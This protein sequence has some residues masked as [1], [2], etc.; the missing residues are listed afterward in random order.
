MSNE[1]RGVALRAA[2]EMDAGRLEAAQAVLA[3]APVTDVGVEVRK[4]YLALWR[5][6]LKSTDRLSRPVAEALDTLDRVMDAPARLWDAYR[7]ITELG[8]V[9]GPLSA[10]IVGVTLWPETLAADADFFPHFF[11][12]VSRGAEAALVEAVWRGF[13]SARRDYAPDHWTHL[14][15]LR[16]RG[17]QARADFPEGVL[18]ELR[19]WGRADLAPLVETQLAFARQAPMQAVCAQALALTDPAHRQAVAL[20]LIG[21]PFDGPDADIVDQ[22]FDALL[23]ADAPQ[24]LAHRALMRARVLTAQGDWRAAA[25]AADAVIHPPA[26]SLT[27]SVLAAN[28][29]ARLGRFNDARRDLRKVARAADA[30]PFLQGRSLLV[31]AVTELLAAGRA[32]PDVEAAAE[33]PHQAGRPLAQSLWVGPRLRWVEQLSIASYLRNGWRYQLYV[34][35]PPAGAPPGCELMDAEAILPREALFR[36][37]GGSGW[38]KG[39]LGAFSDLFRYALLHLK[40]GMWT[41]TDVV[42][43][44]LFEP[45]GRSFMATEMID[46]GVYGPNG[47][48]LAAPAGA[49]FIAEAL[50]RARALIDAEALTFARIG[51][52]LLAEMIAERGPGAFELLPKNFMN[53]VPWLQAATFLRPYETVAAAPEIRAATNIHLYTETWRL[54]GLRLD[55]PPSVDTFLGRLYT[56]LVLADGRQAQG[57][58]T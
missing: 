50:R 47:C 33:F 43:R 13:L 54:V 27:A 35:D 39:S 51:P 22:T 45:D 49:P 44:R 20:F 55:Q 48:L 21:C 42:N 5:R 7:P 2:A 46:G 26:H 12:A 57:V 16:A 9:L 8:R 6:V 18:A 53:P 23:P 36:E 10:P 17:V 29:K 38:H 15:A 25:E 31:G 3:A 56:D 1:L 19:A 14:K 34:Y 30:P 11:D 4:V 52:E 41:D 37:G 24:A 28:A 40:G 32:A 58:T